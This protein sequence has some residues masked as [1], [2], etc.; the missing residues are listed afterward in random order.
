MCSIMKSLDGILVE[1]WQ[2]LLYVSDR[3]IDQNYLLFCLSR[4]QN[5][6]I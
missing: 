2:M 3:V 4:F 1:I 5:L 6:I